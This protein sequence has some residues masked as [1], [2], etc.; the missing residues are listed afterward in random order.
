MTNIYAIKVVIDGSSAE[1]ILNALNQGDAIRRAEDFFARK[2][3]CHAATCS[4][5]P[6]TSI[7]ICGD[8]KEIVPQL[9]GLALGSFAMARQE[10]A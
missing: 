7:L 3:A 1:V 5:K 8:E 6:L 4:C 2:F 9:A 10:R